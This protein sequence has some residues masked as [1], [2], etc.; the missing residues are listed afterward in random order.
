MDFEFDVFVVGTL[1][2]GS[3]F[4]LIHQSWPQNRV[5]VYFKR[6]QNFSENNDHVTFI[7]VEPITVIRP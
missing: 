3:S 1:V 2:L 6:G 7:K 4:L 5:V